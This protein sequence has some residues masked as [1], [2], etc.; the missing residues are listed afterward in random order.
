MSMNDFL[1][2][3]VSGK[4]GNVKITSVDFVEGKFFE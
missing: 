1:V 4:V 3:F 2:C